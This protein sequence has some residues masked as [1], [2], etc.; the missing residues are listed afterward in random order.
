MSDRTTE[1]RKLLVVFNRAPVS[2]TRDPD[3][4]RIAR[5]GGGGVVTALGGLLAHHDVTWVASAMTEED[6]AVAAEQDGSFVEETADGSSYRLRLVAHDPAA[7]DRFYHVLAN[8]TL[9]FLQHYLWGLGSAPDFGPELHEAWSDGYVPVNEALAEAALQELDREPGAAVLFHDYH[10]YVAPRLVREARPDVVTSHFLHIPWPE[11]DYWHALPPELRVAVHEGLLAN[12]VVGFHTERWRRAFLLSAERLLGARVDRG[13]GTVEHHGRTTRVVAHPIS[14]DPA[15]FDRLRS[16]PGVLERE[17]ALVAR[18]PEQLVLRVD[19]TDPSKN[20]VRG[21]H[22]FGL[23]LERHPEL[24][25][26]VGMVALLAP[27]RQDIREY[28]EYVAALEAAARQV[29]DR[30]GRSDWQP[31][32]LDIADDFLRSVAGYKQFDVLLANP[33]F[34]GLNLVAKEAFLVNEHDG[35]L[36]L[37]ENA[38]AHEELEEWVL[39]VNPVDVSGQAEALYAALTLD[40]AERRRRAAAIREHVRVHDIREWVDAQLADLDAV[41]SP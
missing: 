33:V 17:A 3:G 30:F 9:W 34:D 41:R 25:G 4:H 13:A 22:A 28:A 7:Y 38:G 6:R 11:P 40:P 5:R 2:Y 39:T 15:E 18:R 16:D 32:E 19:R 10:L 23:L 35:V 12:D 29:N 24:H 27:S 20:I 1:R 36:V 26:R 14:V 8:P 37:S 21:F 31:V